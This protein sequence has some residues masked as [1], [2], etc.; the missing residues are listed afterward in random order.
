ML[1]AALMAGKGDCVTKVVLKAGMAQD[2]TEAVIVPIG[3]PVIT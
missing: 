3:V 2:A 1:A